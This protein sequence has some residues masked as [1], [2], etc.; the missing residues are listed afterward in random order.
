MRSLFGFCASGKTFQVSRDLWLQLLFNN[1]EKLPNSTEE[2]AA[3]T[4][5]KARELALLAGL[6]E[7]H[8]KSSG[9]MRPAQEPKMKARRRRGRLHGMLVVLL[10][11][12]L[13]QRPTIT[14]GF[15]ARRKNVFSRRTPAALVV[16]P[17]HGN[18]PTSIIVA[19]MALDPTTVVQDLASSLDPLQVAKVGVPALGVLFIA[20][21]TRAPSRLV[22][23]SV[24]DKI[25]AGTFL[26]SRRRDNKLQRV[27]KASKDG[28]SALAFHEAVDGLGSAVVAARSISGQTFGGFNPNGFRSTDDYYISSAAFLWCLKG[29][30]G[31]GTVVKLPVLPGGGNNAAVFDYATSGPCFGAADLQIGPPAAAVLGGFAGPD[32]EDLSNSAGDLRQCTSSV[33]ATYRYDPAWPARGSVRLVEVEVYAIAN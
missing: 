13:L 29:G 8:W 11:L 12:C 6:L 17:F 19:P 1:D 10:V 18:R 14:A 3:I 25:I 22:S 33:G 16:R 31:S 30:G 7:R 26:E 4:Q 5:V 28:W 15:V 2:M 24:L 21:A 9:H 23:P 27:Y 32:P 20:A